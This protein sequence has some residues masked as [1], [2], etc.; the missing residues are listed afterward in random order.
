MANTCL[1]GFVESL[2][3]FGNPLVLGGNFEVSVHQDFLCRGGRA[4]RPRPGRHIL[5]LILLTF[6]LVAFW[7]QQRWLGRASYVTVTGKGDAGLPTPLPK[8]VSAL[9]Y[10]TALPWAFFTAVLYLV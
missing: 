3:D 6:T 5:A 4:K 1:L 10:A 9:C 7:L 2:A 8:R